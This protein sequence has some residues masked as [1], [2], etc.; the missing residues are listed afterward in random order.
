MKILLFGTRKYQNIKH[1]IIDEM[2]DYNA[3]QY[4]ILNRIFDCNMTI[5][6]D[7]QQVIY[8]TND[9]VI[10]KPKNMFHDNIKVTKIMKS[11]RSTYEIIE[12]CK[13]I[14]NVKNME[15]FD[16]HGKEPLIVKCDDYMKMVEEIEK[17]MNYVNLNSYTTVAIICKS[18]RLAQDFYNNI[19]NKDDYYLMNDE[20]VE[21]KEG[22]IITNAF[23]AKGLEFDM[24][25]IPEVTKTDFNTDIDRQILYVA[26]T[27]ALHEL[28]LYYYDELSE[29][30]Q[31]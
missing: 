22:K 17:T 21:F 12:F 28:Y 18:K 20:N 25:I 1:V 9:D 15:P 11:Y 27:R 14:C 6:G 8:K 30:I 5:L 16:R 3:T 19:K 24:V 31:K 7:V 2:Q 23:L 13:K 4:E 10:E 29:F 26:C